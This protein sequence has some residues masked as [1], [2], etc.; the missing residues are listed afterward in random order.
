M[1]PALAAL[2]ALAL[3]LASPVAAGEITLEAVPVPELKSVYGQVQAKDSV[4]ARARIPGTLVSLDVSEGSMVRAGDVIARINDDKIDFQIKAMDAQLL[5]LEASLADVRSDLER[6]RRLSASGLATAQRLDQLRAQVEVTLNQ[7]KAT[8]AQRSV[9]VEQ[10]GEGVVLAPA[11]G[12]VVSVPV[13]RNAVMMAG[14]TVATIAGGGFFLR[15]AIPER[16][17]EALEQGA[18]IEIEAGGKAQAGKL[19]KIYPEIAG[20]RVTADV[21]VPGL[22]TDFV[23]ARVLVRLPVG[24]RAALLVPPSVVTTRAGLDF[25]TVREGDNTV[26]RAVVTGRRLARNGVETVEILTGLAAGDIL[27]TP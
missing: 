23:G 1:K 24:E 16:H 18:D 12:K 11:T 19:A 25:V 26:E 10:A 13:T 8:Q 2:L 21:E 22:N 9:L 5:G 4:P 17:A 6:T 27:V 7:I 15:L 14:E 20:G 3:P